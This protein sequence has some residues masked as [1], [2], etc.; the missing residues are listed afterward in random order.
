MYEASPKIDWRTDLYARLS[1]LE[2]DLGGSAVRVTGVGGVRLMRVIALMSGDPYRPQWLAG[3]YDRWKPWSFYIGQGRS[4]VPGLHLLASVCDVAARRW[5]DS[6]DAVAESSVA[7]PSHHRRSP[8]GM[9]VVVAGGS[10]A[11]AMFVFSLPHHL[12]RDYTAAQVV[13]VAKKEV[14]RMQVPQ[15]ESMV[16]NPPAR[17]TSAEVVPVNSHVTLFRV[18]VNGTGRV[19][20]HSSGKPHHS[21]R[22]NR[23]A[24]APSRRSHLLAGPMVQENETLTGNQLEGLHGDTVPVAPTRYEANS[25]EWST[26]I[27]QRRVTEIPEQF[28]Y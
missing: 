6:S 1:A 23:H 2:A 3:Q 20:P 5:L 27:T 18:P 19:L 10:V 24:N 16:G 9:A 17:T 28:G 15:V 14:P 8:W 25:T 4:Q 21:G 26:H 11:L 7:V 12:W 13:S 22:E